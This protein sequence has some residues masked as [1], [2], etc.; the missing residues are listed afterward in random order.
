MWAFKALQGASVARSPFIA[1][2]ENVLCP[3]CA[4]VA[5]PARASRRAACACS[6]SRCLR[7]RRGAL[8]ARAS[9][10]AACACFALRCLRVRHATCACAT[11]PKFASRGMRLHRAACACVALPALRCLRLRRAEL[12]ARAPRCLR[13]RHAA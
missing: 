2:T 9:R 13:V 5:L 11:L 10:C 7:V 8:P 4:C 12:P 3:I 6:S 1:N